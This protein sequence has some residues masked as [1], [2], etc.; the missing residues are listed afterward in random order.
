MYFTVYFIIQNAGDAE[1][2]LVGNK[3]DLV[4]R[5][6]VEEMAGR[7]LAHEHGIAYIETSALKDENFHEV[8]VVRIRKPWGISITCV[9][10]TCL[11]NL[12]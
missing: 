12:S 1:I 9:F 3:T 10:Y 5:R 4:S 8:S 2:V 11:S 7:Y 6:V